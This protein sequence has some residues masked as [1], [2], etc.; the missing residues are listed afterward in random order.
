MKQFVVF[1]YSIPTMITYMYITA[2]SYCFIVE[3]LKFIKDDNFLKTINTR[4]E[5][6]RDPLWWFET[7]LNLCVYTYKYSSRNN[8]TQKCVTIVYA[9]SI[10][11]YRIAAETVAIISFV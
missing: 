10:A 11:I 8:K 3:W 4:Y 2:V 9:R 1:R 5:R 7:N 6:T